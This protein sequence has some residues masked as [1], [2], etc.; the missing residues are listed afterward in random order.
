MDCWNWLKSMV[1]SLMISHF[2]WFAIAFAVTTRVLSKPLARSSDDMA[3]DTSSSAQSIQE[4]RSNKNQFR[5]QHAKRIHGLDEEKRED[6][7]FV[8]TQGRNGQYVYTFSA[9]YIE[10]NTM[11]DDATCWLWDPWWLRFVHNRLKTM[12]CQH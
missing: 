7:G 9:F 2:R 8:F 5:L 10:D 1:T 12:D 6:V 4:Q 11:A 3:R